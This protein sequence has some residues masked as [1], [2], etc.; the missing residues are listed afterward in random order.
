M[1]MPVKNVVKSYM[2]TVG[3]KVPDAVALQKS[4]WYRMPAQKPAPT[5]AI[6]QELDV[7]VP[8]YQICC[9][10]LV[11]GQL[12]VGELKWAVGAGHGMAAGKE[13]MIMTGVK[14]RPPLSCVAQSATSG[15]MQALDRSRP[16]TVTIE[17]PTWRPG[18]RK[19]IQTWTW[20][21]GKPASRLAQRGT[22]EVGVEA[23]SGSVVGE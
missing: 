23:D 6:S 14:M 7:I 3:T 20:R 9:H 2:N 8:L 1:Y 19:R 22:R 18:T 4:C 21:S 11:V 13:I 17:V 12:G 5:P 16:Y 15:T 10:M